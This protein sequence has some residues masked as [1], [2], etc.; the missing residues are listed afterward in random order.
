MKRMKED[1]EKDGEK[2]KVDTI[3]GQLDELSET[4]KN[5]SKFKYN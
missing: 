2:P 4:L 1:E 5:L 3:P